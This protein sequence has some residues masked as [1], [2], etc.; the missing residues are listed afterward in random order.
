MVTGPVQGSMEW[1]QA[2]SP[3]YHG[4]EGDWQCTD[5]GREEGNDWNNL[6]EFQDP[7]VEW[8]APNREA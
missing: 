3:A 8:L 7:G 2:C 6:Y 5:P 4:P 1:M